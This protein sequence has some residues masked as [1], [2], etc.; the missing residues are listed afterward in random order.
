[1]PSLSW[2]K[3]SYWN[4]GK[5]DKLTLENKLFKIKT[6]CY[7]NSNV[8][9]GKKLKQM[10]K[11][12]FILLGKLLKCLMLYLSQLNHICQ[13]LSIGQH[14]QNIEWLQ[15]KERSTQS[16]K[17]QRNWHKRINFC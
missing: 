8:L 17:V 6:L 11:W 14:Q 1:M 15:Q 10:Q 3:E 9:L 7:A 4:T 12:L 2:S 13:I 16:K 5:W